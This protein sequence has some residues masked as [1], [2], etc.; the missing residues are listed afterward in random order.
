MARVVVIEDNEDLAEV[1]RLALV[2][3]G[4]EV[5]GVYDEP[6]P[7]LRGADPARPADLVLLDERLGGRS[8]S[9]FLA[10]LRQAHPGARF[11]LVSADPEAVAAAPRRGFDGARRKPLPILEILEKVRELLKPPGD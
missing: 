2:S 11:L 5:L 10:P 7:A 6:E 4:H 8:G 3:A 9:A 1:Y